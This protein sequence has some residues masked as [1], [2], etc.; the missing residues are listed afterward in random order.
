MVF[1]CGHTFCAPRHERKHTY[2]LQARVWCVLVWRQALGYRVGLTR[3]VRAAGRKCV[4]KVYD[5]AKQLPAKRGSAL[6]AR[7]QAYAGNNSM[8]LS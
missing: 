2:T 3:H 8:V 7:A 1:E 5:M 4:N 6:A